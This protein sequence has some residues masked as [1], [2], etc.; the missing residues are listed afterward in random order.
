MFD[1]ILVADWSA[2]A[3]PTGPRPKKDAIWVCADLKGAQTVEYF[4]T[5]AAALAWIDDWLG[6]GHRTLLGFDFAFGYP[7]GFAAALTGQEGALGLWDWLAARIEDAPDNANNR[8]E[9]AAAINRQFPGTGPFWGRPAALDLPDL[10][11]TDTARAGHGLPEK[12]AVEAVVPGAKTLW[13]LAYG[14]AVGSQSLVGLAALSRLRARWGAEMQVW[15]QET[16]FRLPETGN[17]LVEIY[18]SLWPPAPHEIKDAGQVMATATALRT[19]SPDWFTAPGAQPDAERIAREE[20]WI[21]GVQ[22]AG[23]CYALPPGVHWT[24]VAEALAALRSRT[25]CVTGQEDVLVERAAGRIL[26]APLSAHRSHPPAANSAV[27]GWGFAHANLAPGPI[28][29]A[30]G[31]AAA[32]TTRA[33]PVPPGSAIRILTGAALPPGVDTVALQEDARVDGGLLYLRAVPKAG[34]NTRPMGEDITEGTAILGAGTRLRP[35]D[36]ALAIA[37]GVA[38]VGVRRPLRVGVLSTGDEII[39]PGA[40][41]PG[42]HDVNRPM[43]LA[44]LAGWGLAPVD[45]GHVPDERAALRSALDAAEVDAILTS[46]GASAGDEDHLSRLLSE[47][48][49]VQHWRIA[50]KPGR[51]LALGDWRGKP[52]FG[53]PGNPVAAFTCAALFA[54]PALLQMAG[55]GWREPTPI[56]VPAAFTKRKKPGRVEVLRARLRE[57][58]AEV[59]V[60]EGSGRVSGLSWAEGFVMLPEGA[61]TIAPGDPVD[62]I[63]FAELDLG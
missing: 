18:P 23:D 30:P 34:A 63:P 14:G 12:R 6:Q 29:V 26:A 55:A 40:A 36:V 3:K 39:A 10:P 45:L 43:L 11:P 44:M 60:S 32:D 50:I 15:P 8:F 16:G 22:A 62:Y 7:Q 59:F 33:D 56:T 35:T 42:I 49:E 57:G 21:L 19:A 9:V 5:R 27:D 41:G 1:L 20:G 58:R 47:E 2:A 13:Q 17:L 46:G 28:P 52:L 38:T 37:A 4:P 24:P 51:P 54:R 61:A 31:R 53:L 48:G 25:A